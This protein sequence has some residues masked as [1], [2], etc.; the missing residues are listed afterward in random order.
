MKLTHKILVACFGIFLTQQVHAQIPVEVFAGHKQIQYQGYFFKT[1]D[2]KQRVSF[3]GM[4]R[5]ASDYE[6]EAF[7]SSLISSQ[8]TYNFSQSWGLST[9]L[10]FANNELAPIAAL[11]YSKFNKKGDFFINLFPTVILSEETSYEIT[12]LAIYSPKLTDN[13]SL[14]TQLIFVSQF[15]KQLDQ[16]LFSNQQLRVGVGIKDW[17]QVGVGIDNTMLGPIGSDAEGNAGVPSLDFQN[18]GIFLRKDL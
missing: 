18:V 3:F 6:N 16:H 9:G 12:G 15:N 1:L 5:F 13:L 8:V 2:Q 14:F 17:F 7:N 4:S 11:S 10:T